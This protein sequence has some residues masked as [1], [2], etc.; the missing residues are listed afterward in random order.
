M[1]MLLVIKLTYVC[2]GIGFLDVYLFHKHE[3][4]IKTYKIIVCNTIVKYNSVK[5]YNSFLASLQ[6]SPFLYYEYVLLSFV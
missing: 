2:L 4:C 5:N 3:L 1:E 6:N